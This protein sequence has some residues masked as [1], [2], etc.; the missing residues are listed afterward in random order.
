MPIIEQTVEPLFA[1]PLIHG[2]LDRD[3]TQD[4][5]D[6]IKEQREVGVPKEYPGNYFSAYSY[7]LEDKRMANLK[8]DLLAFLEIWFKEVIPSSQAKNYITQS[9]INYTRKIEHHQRHMHPNSYLSGVLY[10]AGDDLDY[11]MFENPLVASQQIQI[12]ADKPAQRNPYNTYMSMVP[13]KPGDIV[14]FPSTLYH[15]TGARDS[16]K[17]RISLAFNTFIDGLIGSYERITEL[18]LRRKNYQNAT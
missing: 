17:P 1:V 14:L 6:L 15:S 16:E 18:D 8:A 3:F 12:Y 13:I 7:V 2:R 4:E 5:L 10:V 11:I 9:W